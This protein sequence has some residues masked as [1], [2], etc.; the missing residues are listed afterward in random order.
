MRALLKPVL[1]VLCILPASMAVGDRPEGRALTG[2]GPENDAAPVVIDPETAEDGSPYPGV[3]AP[4]GTGAAGKVDLD[5]IE[6]AFGQD[7]VDVY[8]FLA[9]PATESR[10]DLDA[11]RAPHEQE[12]KRLSEDIREIELRYRSLLSLPPESEKLEARTV[13]SMI[14][15]ED[16]ELR[17]SL[18]FEIDDRL[19]LMRQDVGNALRGQVA[20]VQAAV[21][22]DVA[23]LGGQVHAR[24]PL[25]N[26]LLATVPSASLTELGEHPSILRVAMRNE[27]VPLLNVSCSAGSWTTWHTNGYDGGA[28]D[29]GVSDTGVQEDHPAFAGLNFYTNETSH[30]DPDGHGTHVTGIIASGD[31][32]YRGTAYGLDA[33]IWGPAGGSSFATF[34]AAATGFAQSAESINLSWG[35]AIA[36]V[37]DYNYESEWFDTYVEAFDVMAT[38]AA[39]N[40]GWSDTLPRLRHPSAG[41]N[42][43]TVANMRD[44]GNAGRTGDV[45]SGDSSV[46]PTLNG[47]RKPDIS[48]PGDWISSANAFWSGPD[49][50]GG[51][52]WM[53]PPSNDDFVAC[54]GTSMASPHVTG[55][56]VLLH[57][58]GVTDSLAQKAVLFNTADWWTSNDT[59]GT[60]D[61]G[62]VTTPAGAG[63]TN[64]DKSY[65]WGYID[66]DHAYTHRTD[67]FLSSVVPRNDTANEDDYKLFTG[68][69][70]AGEKATLVWEKRGYYH[71]DKLSTWT[72][73]L[74]DL[75]LR[76]YDGDNGALVDYDLVGIDNVHQV[77]TSSNRVGVVKVYA[78]SGSFDG[79]SSEAFGLGT[80]ENWVAADFPDSFA[81]YG[82]WPGTVQPNEEVDFTFWV[83]NNSTL[84]SHSNTFELVLPAGWT[85]VSGS[86]STGVGSVAGGGSDSTAVTWRVRAQSTPQTGLIVGSRHS[87]S[88][89]DESYGPFTWNMGVSVVQD[90]TPPSPNPLGWWN[91]PSKLSTSQLF[92]TAAEATDD[93]GPV[94]YQFDFTNSPTGGG[95]GTDSAWQTSRDYTDSGLLANHEY[96]YRARA[97]DNPTTTPNYTGF[98]YTDCSYTSI[99]TPTGI[100]FSTVTTSSIQARSANTPSGLTRDNS[101]LKV[102]N[103]TRGTDSGWKQDNNYWTSTGLAANTPYT[104]H[105]QARNGEG[106]ATPYSPNGTKY[107]LA[108]V[109]GALGF[110]NVN[111]TSIQVN[112]TSNGNPAGTFY[113]VENVTTG[114]VYG[115]TTGTSWTNGG[116][117]CGNTYEYRVKARNGDNVETGWLTLGTRRAGLDSEGDSVPDCVDPDDD[118]DGVLDGADCARL[119]VNTWAVPG[120]V[121]GLVLTASG[122]S[123]TLQWSAPA[124]PGG[125]S[126]LFDVISSP[127][128]SDLQG[129]S[130]VATNTRDRAAPDVAVPALAEAFYYVV[131]AGN[132][133][134]EGTSGSDSQG[135]PRAALPCP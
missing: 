107:T 8:L 36:D 13:E 89:Y 86:T 109:P 6:T 73:A 47:R 96:C 64:W 43:I 130:C 44:M 125:T 30:T 27:G 49:T 65:G 111:D 92:M 68:E 77:A 20:P 14:T 66:M 40:E 9:L 74:S 48:A 133:C 25:G 114:Q 99:E 70:F 94:Q 106:L 24:V 35:Y 123:T 58:G 126:L 61:D 72:Y 103:Q 1:L 84:A 22:I 134:G 28:F 41:Y 16:R 67:Y 90:V 3:R 95:G 45:R 124:A 105:A 54:S 19:H 115:W 29:A 100:A 46:G 98:T 116:L 2:H 57:E 18:Q 63:I 127:M 56:V 51:H 4:K 52:C 128:A 129:G 5:V 21:A 132:A 11:I 71:P 81:G 118:N 78:W 55:A 135:N 17:R 121:R 10:L 69:M 79:A 26:V 75:N 59:P 104:F 122:S 32:T 76:L 108:N 88:S 15:Q 131:R 117:Y 119:D 33:L 42:P 38:I 93:H 102:S 12:L 82:S 31:T 50:G 120:E 7:S 34:D 53:D 91:S 39:G 97:R 80:E 23:H 62:E 113:W 110:S 101:G 87:H 112:W 83:R 85:L 60:G 37:E